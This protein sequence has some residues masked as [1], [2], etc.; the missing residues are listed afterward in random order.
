MVKRRVEVD[1]VGEGL[2]EILQARGVKYFFG[3]GA[4]TDFPPI[5]EA[6][7]KRA[8][9]GTGNRSDHELEP[10]TVMHEITAVAMAHGYTMVSGEPQAV[11]LHTTVGTANA[12]GGIVNASRGRVPMFVAAGRPSITESGH[13]T[14]KSQGIHWAQES[15]DQA[16]MLREYVKWDY[17]LRRGEQLEAVVDRA[18]AIGQNPPAGPTYL[19]L[20]LE[21]LGGPLGTLEYDEVPRL[22]PSLPGR[23]GREAIEQ[24][25]ELLARAR[26]PVAITASLGRDPNAVA[27]LQS[28]A[29]RLAMPVIEFWN[30]HLNFPQDHPL[31]Q[32]YL[33]APFIQD[34]DVIAVIEADAPWFPRDTEPAEGATIIQIDED[35]LYERFPTRGFPTD[36]GLAGNPRLTLSALDAALAARQL[37]ESAIAA[38]RARCARDHQKQRTAWQS[39]GEAASGETPLEPA[40]VSRCL[41]AQMGEDDIAVTE[42]ALDRTQMCFTRP[43]TYFN[44]AHSGGL[45][46]APGAALG[47]KLA[48]PDRTVICA[49]G[50]GSHVF[51]VPTSTHYMARACDLPVLFVV[52][53]NA[54]WDRTR[55]AT[56]D[57]APDGWAAKTKSMPLCELQPAPDYERICQA[58]GGY[59]ERVENPAELPAALSRAL[60]VVREEG[61]Q[62]LLNVISSKS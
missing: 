59:G 49:M 47:A 21:V 3:G 34:A 14:S 45:G 48:N 26:N 46:W 17:E 35:P 9:L 11:M 30:T 58:A 42:I 44:H 33:S 2:L 61:R 50:D 38:R 52:F 6:F 23:P 18:L 4:G 7:A 62:A 54:A 19:T 39:A 41:A 55:L 24:A 32:G 36:L 43:G 25:A 5:I 12:V 51:G 10:V 22:R 20:P 16:G 15:Y 28:L 60:T 13:V 56:L 37:D 40:W 8:A 57:F 27:A 53:N 29:D 1:S 31:H